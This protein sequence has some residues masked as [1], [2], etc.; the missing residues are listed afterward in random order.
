MVKC[1]GAQQKLES[2]ELRQRPATWKQRYQEKAPLKASALDFTA[3]YSIMWSGINRALD[4]RAGKALAGHVDNFPT[5]QR[6]I[7]LA[8]YLLGLYRACF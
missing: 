3:S 5:S 6:K 4:L 7:L 8:E 2:A 1:P